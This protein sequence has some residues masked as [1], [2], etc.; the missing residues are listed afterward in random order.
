MY[1][2]LIK[3]AFIVNGKNEPTFVGDVAIN[4][5]T[6]VAV[7]NFPK[8]VESVSKEVI[9]GTGL[10]LTPGFIDIHCHSDAIIFSQEKNIKRLWNG[11]TTELIGNCGISAAP[12][13]E[14]HIQELRKYNNPFYSNIPVNYE[15]WRGFGEYLDYVEKTGPVLNTAAL[16][17]HGALRVAIAGFDNRKLHGEELEE[18]KMLLIDCM[19]QGAYG[20]SSGLIYPPGIYADDHEI[21]E[22]VKVVREKGGLYSTHMRNEGE[23]LEQSVQ[24]VIELATKTGANVE[25]SHHKA[26]GLRNHGKVAGTI[27]M[28]EEARKSGVRIDCDTYPYTACSTQFSAVLPPW[29]FEGGVKELIKRLQDAN[30]R[31]RVIE[32]L[33]SGS[34]SF[35]NYYDHAGWENII[36]NECAI[37]EYEGKSVS[38]IAS[39]KG[40]DPFEMALDILLESQ[41][42]AMMICF[43]IGEEDIHSSYTSDLSIVC[44]DGFP[45]IGKSH[46][47]YL[48]S[49]IRVLEKYVRDEKFLTL[50]NAVY[51][52]TGKPAKKIGLANRGIIEEGKK[53]DL[54][55]FNMKELHDNATYEKSDGLAD[56]IKYVFINGEKAVC[57]GEYRNICIGKVLRKNDE[58]YSVH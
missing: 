57:N 25:V 22:L 34:T 28:M 27:K 13:R 50:E 41:N 54:V 33:K 56:G 4:A 16:V 39:V 53:A 49:F 17:G 51:K 43:C 1:D 9:D 52:M 7:G 37:K 46:P 36:I 14:E 8:S 44:T 3:N 32:E 2:I 6:I 26:M 15:A 20:L 47:R 12:V 55:L 21:S 31:E 35:E 38:E 58:T 30:C 42:E 23:L 24:S 5:D 29:M 40:K 19:K 45:A 10:V 11:V 48:G 18:M